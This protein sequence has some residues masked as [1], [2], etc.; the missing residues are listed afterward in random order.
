[1]SLWDG[2]K[3]IMN[4]SDDDYEDE[5]EVVETAEY[6]EPVRKEPI[7]KESTRKGKTV[8]FSNANTNIITIKIGEYQ[9]DQINDLGIKM[10]Q[11]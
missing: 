7:K 11:T 9:T 4:V 10:L 6:N 5:N 1:M 2:I 8:P 3:N